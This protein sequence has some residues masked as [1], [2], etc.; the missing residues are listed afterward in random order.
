MNPVEQIKDEVAKKDKS[1]FLTFLVFL[2]ISTILWS[3]IKLTKEYT[4]QTTFT[5]SY[6]NIPVNKW[7]S[8]PEQQ[9]KLSFVA[10]GFATLRHNLL[11]SHRRVIVIPLDEVSFHH[12]GG[13]TYSYGSQYV[14][15][16]VASR[17]DITSSNVTMNDD[18]QYFNM[19]DLQ[20]KA[21]PVHVP[22][23]IVTQRQ[24]LVYGAPM[25][26]PSTITVYGPK[27]VLDTMTAVYT[28]ELS[29]TNASE[30]VEQDLAIDFYDGSIRAEEKTVHVVVDVVQYT[31]IDIQVPVKL[32]NT[33]NV[34]F[35][36]ETMNVKC[37]VP[38][39]DYASLNS[40]A[41]LVY[42]DTAQ[43]RQLKPLLDIHLVSTPPFVQVLK[44]EPE[45]VEYLIVN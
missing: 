5:V 8:T 38:I 42:A 7:V 45:Q 11:G 4:T 24:Y 20:M 15:D 27:N 3:L 14:A 19:E 9:V 12:E 39:K 10:N 40:N 18:K 13:N 37:M 30:A 1:K 32:P 33:M 29:A 44:T 2:I 21:L 41:F 6:S 16:R 35:F 26:T 31:E 17:L 28:H 34:R 22:L 43:L 25:V 23:N 36:P